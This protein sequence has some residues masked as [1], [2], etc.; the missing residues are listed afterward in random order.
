CNNFH[1]FQL[2]MQ[3][4]DIAA[5]KTIVAEYDN[6]HT[7]QGLRTIFD[8]M[9]LAPDNKIY[10]STYEGSDVFHVINA[11][12]SAGVDCRVTQHSFQLP[13]YNAFSMPNVPNYALG[14]LNGS[15]CDSLNISINE[16]E[17]DNLFV[18]YPNPSNGKI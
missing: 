9:K 17:K 13:D 8:L 11:P 5:S 6:F 1:I 2:D 15:V 3:A 7:V 14:A 18:L 4:T 10:I 12:D 16:I